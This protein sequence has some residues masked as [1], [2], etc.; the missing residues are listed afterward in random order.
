[1]AKLTGLKKY[2]FGYYNYGKIHGDPFTFLLDGIWCWLRYGCVFTSVRD[3][4]VV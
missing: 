3:K 1:M 2:I 4:K